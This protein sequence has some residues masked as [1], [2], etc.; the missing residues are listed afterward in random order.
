M[1]GRGKKFTFHGQF[2]SKRAA[3]EKEKEVG[4]GAFIIEERKAGI[5]HYYVVTK[6]R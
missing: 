1:A 6:R 2:I 5:K 3:M 4:K